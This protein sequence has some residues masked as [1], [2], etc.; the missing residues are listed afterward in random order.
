ML[1]ILDAKYQPADL[2]K[3]AAKNKNLMLEQQKKLHELLK[4]HE[5]LFDGT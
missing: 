4:N 5:I 1:K 2:D 3:V